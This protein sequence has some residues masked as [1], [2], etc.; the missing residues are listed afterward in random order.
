[1]ETLVS[2]LSLKKM[3][4]AALIALRSDVQ[5]A[6]ASKIGEERA[7]LQKQIDALSKLENGAGGSLNGSRSPRR[8]H[9]STVRRKPKAV[10][11][12]KVA[13]KYRGPEGETWTGR[14]NA[15]RWLVALEAQGKK[16]ESFLI[17]K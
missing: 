3:P 7:A 11:I 5:A 13:S 17:K 8:R 12:R 4:F 14:G 16:R 1:M 10:Q 15:P 2:K 9:G 6:I